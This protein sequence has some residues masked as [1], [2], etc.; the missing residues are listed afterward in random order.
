S[1]AGELFTFS[2]IKTQEEFIARQKKCHN[3]SSKTNCRYFTIGCKWVDSPAKIDPTTHKESKSIA[4]CVAKCEDIKGDMGCPEYCSPPLDVTKQGCVF[5]DSIEHSAIS[6]EREHALCLA[7]AKTDSTKLSPFG[8]TCPSLTASILYDD[9]KTRINYCQKTLFHEGQA[10]VEAC[11]KECGDFLEGA[12]AC[13]ADEKP[14]RCGLNDNCADSDG[15]CH[16]DC[17][18]MHYI[19]DNMGLLEKDRQAAIEIACKKYSKFCGYRSSL[20]KC[21]ENRILGTRY[22]ATDNE[23]QAKDVYLG[24]I[25]ECG[26]ECA[27]FSECVATNVNGLIRCDIRCEEI[28]DRN[29]CNVSPHCDWI[30]DSCRIKDSV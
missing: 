25:K 29:L 22:Y 4:Q 26:K 9:D 3:I 14:C 1:Q 15:G 7:K 20:N 17:E 21:L 18:L 19:Y 27:N 30:M 12:C 23:K 28:R 8:C 5:S 24:F 11:S 2:S 16:I 6:L 10:E 13:A